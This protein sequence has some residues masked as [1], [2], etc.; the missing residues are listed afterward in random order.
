MFKINML[1][2]CS[3]V[4]FFCVLPVANAAED[5]CKD[6]LFYAPL[7]SPVAFDRKGNSIRS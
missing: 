3:V 6:V 1:L 5:W 4:L 2:R 7:D